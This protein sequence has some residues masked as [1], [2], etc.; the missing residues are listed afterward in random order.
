VALAL[1]FHLCSPR[2]RCWLLWQRLLVPK[3]LP[4]VTKMETPTWCTLEAVRFS[5]L[6]DRSVFVVLVFL[7]IRHLACSLLHSAYPSKFFDPLSTLMPYCHCQIRSLPR[8]LHVSAGFLYVRE[9][10][11]RLRCSAL[12]TDFDGAGMHV[13]YACGAFTS[14]STFYV[15]DKAVVFPQHNQSNLVHMKLSVRCV[16]C[17]SPPDRAS[18]KTLTPSR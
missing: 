1:R 5:R 16:R 17:H 10:P 12:N 9:H 18:W 14:A 15:R 8:T 13:H 2:P 4:S 6:R 11:S 7:S 3:D